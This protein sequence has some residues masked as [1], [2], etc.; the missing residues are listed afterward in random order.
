MDLCLNY[1]ENKIKKSRQGYLYYFNNMT[2]YNQKTSS[3]VVLAVNRAKRKTMK[4]RTTWT[5]AFHFALIL[6]RW[7]YS[8]QGGKHWRERRAIRSPSIF[9]RNLRAVFDFS[10]SPFILILAADAA[11][12]GS[13]HLCSPPS[14][15]VTDTQICR[16]PT[17]CPC[18]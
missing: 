16:A 12:T 10:R 8:E 17:A 13:L 6:D 5:A 9:L 4:S 2:F 7:C 3:H 15:Q 14:T 11:V 1:T 18:Q